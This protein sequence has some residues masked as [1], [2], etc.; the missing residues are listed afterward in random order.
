M[1]DFTDGNLSNSVRSRKEVMRSI[2]KRAFQENRGAEAILLIQWR[3]A[4]VAHQA[5][6]DVAKLKKFEA[7]NRGQPRAIRALN[8]IEEMNGRNVIHKLVE[9]PKNIFE[10]IAGVP[11]DQQIIYEPDSLKGLV[12][13]TPKEN[14][15]IAPRR[16]FDLAT[17]PAFDADRYDPMEGLVLDDTAYAMASRA[18]AEVA[19]RPELPKANAAIDATTLPAPALK[20]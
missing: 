20:Q 9:K 10:L 3:K 18:Y 13:Y 8:M 17:M 19:D 1:L 16:S 12:P 7:D 11:K 4:L 6:S 5:E 2:L 14:R 15:I